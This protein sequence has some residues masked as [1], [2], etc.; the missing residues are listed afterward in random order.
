MHERQLGRLAAQPKCRAPFLSGLL[1]CVSSALRQVCG[2]SFLRG[3]L[4]GLLRGAHMSI[5]LSARWMEG[6]LRHAPPSSAAGVPCSLASRA[7]QRGTAPTGKAISCLRKVVPVAGQQ[8]Q[9]RPAP[10]TTLRAAAAAA[11]PRSGALG[12]LQLD[13]RKRRR[14]RELTEIAQVQKHACTPL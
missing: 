8:Q 7:L 2:K 13:H 3:L 10:S 11:A 1:C 9:S 5:P 6:I 14:E 4:R 12:S